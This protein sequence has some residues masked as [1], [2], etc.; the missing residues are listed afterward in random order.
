M[1]SAKRPLF[2]ASIPFHENMIALVDEICTPIEKATHGDAVGLRRSYRVEPNTNFVTC[3]EDA[4][5]IVKQGDHHRF[6]PWHTLMSEEDFGYDLD[7]IRRIAR[8]FNAPERLPLGSETD[9][10]RSMQHADIDT[11]V[12]LCSLPGHSFV[13]NRTMFEDDFISE[14]DTRSALES[15]IPELAILL[16]PEGVT[17]NHMLRSH[18]RNLEKTNELIDQF[19][20]L[21][22]LDTNEKISPEID[23]EGFRTRMNK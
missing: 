13:Y 12:G 7:A 15:I 10:F 17:S 18:L 8:Y 2:A 6:L 3:L 21:F 19:F 4:D 5:L 9:A 1:T 11:V 22:D 16:L 23:L 20:P 14:Y